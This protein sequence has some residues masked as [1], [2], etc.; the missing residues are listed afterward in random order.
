[1]SSSEPIHSP[2]GNGGTRAITD[3]DL[4]GSHVV[5]YRAILGRPVELLGQTV[6][7]REYYEKDLGVNVPRYM[8]DYRQ[9]MRYIT[10][11]TDLVRKIKSDDY[12][13][14]ASAEQKLADGR[15]FMSYDI[16]AAVWH[17][18]RREVLMLD[19][20]IGDKMFQRMY[21]SAIGHRA[22]EIRALVKRFCE[23]PRRQFKKRPLNFTHMPLVA[24]DMD[25]KPS[26]G[27]K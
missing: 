15:L 17:P 6:L 9:H 5:F 16:H 7:N 4:I 11:Y 3:E 21:G 14:T 13:Q 22:D 12:K 1:M 19:V 10:S 8:E 27:K 20:A 26:L 23:I 2:V 24:E 25:V 18:K